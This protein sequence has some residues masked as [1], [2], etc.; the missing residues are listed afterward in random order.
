MSYVIPVILLYLIF[1]GFVSIV[2]SAYAHPVINIPVALMMVVMY[3]SVQI[4]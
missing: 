2:D 3:N 4:Y 1:T